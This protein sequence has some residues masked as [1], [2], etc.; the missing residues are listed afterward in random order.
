MINPDLVAAIRAEVIQ[1]RSEGLDEE[2]ISFMAQGAGVRL[3]REQGVIG[4]DEVSPEMHAAIS[5]AVKEV[6]NGRR[7]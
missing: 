6:M 5:V 3:A 4:E 7:A 2:D 1:A